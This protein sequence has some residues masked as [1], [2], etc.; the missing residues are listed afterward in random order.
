MFRRLLP[1]LPFPGRRS[2]PTAAPSRLPGIL[3]LVTAG[4]LTTSGLAQAAP[5]APAC[6]AGEFCLWD[7]ETYSGGVRS[8]DLRAANP[9][10][11]IPLPEGFQGHSFVNRMTRDVTIYQGADC[12]TEGDFITYPGGGTY[13]PQSPF[14]VRALKVWE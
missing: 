6:G 9:G 10:D 4:L 3:L 13:V 14:A 5:P 7:T 8:Y 12:S 1:S 2:W 11:C